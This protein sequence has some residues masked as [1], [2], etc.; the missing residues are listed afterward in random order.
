M[1]PFSINTNRQ[2]KGAYYRDASS[3]DS[4]LA[5]RI[6]LFAVN[7]SDDPVGYRAPGIPCSSSLTRFQVALKQAMP[8]LE[9]Q[10]TPYAVLCMTSMGGHLSYW[11][12]GGSRWH[13]KPVGSPSTHWALL[14]F[15]RSSISSTQWRSI[16]PSTL[17]VM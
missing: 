13:V 8:Y 6:P 4:L 9:V 3:V 15:S 5:V 12:I 1:E 17:L 16:S 2:M 7:S 14:I 11:E 10:Q